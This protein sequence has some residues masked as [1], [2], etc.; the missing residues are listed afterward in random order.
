MKK[1]LIA[2]RLHP[3]A[4]EIL[5]A[6]GQYE[7]VQ[8]HSRPLEELAC[9]HSDTYALIVR[10][11]RVTPAIMD[12]MPSLK[13]IVRAGSGF[14]TIDVRYARQRGIDVMTT[15]GANANAVAE[16]V[17]AM[18][19]ADA[20]H[21]IAADISTRAGKWEKD[22]FMGREIAGKTV[23]IVGLGNV[24]RLVARR[25]AG[26]EVRLLAYDPN[27]STER[28]AELGV[29]MTDPTTL[30]SMADYITLH[31]PETEETRGFVNA[32]LL[33][34]LRAG[35]TIVNCARSGV[36]DEDALRSAKLEKGIRYLTDVYPEDGPGPKSIADVAD[37]MLPHLGANTVEAAVKA[38]RRAAEQLIDLDQKGITTFVVNRGVPEGLDEAYCDLA[39]KLARLCRSLLGMNVHLKLIETS[40]YGSLRP[41]AQWLLVPVVAGISEDFDRFM[42]YRAARRFLAEAG[43]DYVDREGDPR[44][45]YENSITVDLTGELEPGTLRHVSI[46]GTVAEGT[47]MV[48]RINEFNKLYFD[49][50]GDTVVFMY[51]DYPGILGTIGAGLA[52]AGVN[53]EDIRCPHELRTNR[54]LAILKVNR[55]PPPDVV[56]GIGRKIRAI[57]ACAI[58]L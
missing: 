5:M 33:K 32:G 51:E 13:V 22:R 21:I 35:A 10:S 1:V 9:I 47:L 3:V 26:F 52:A 42:D 30:F 24:G 25:L 49:P 19:L 38:A 16:E 20:R 27:V 57:T 29:E 53:I 12:A 36:V 8:D 4:R 45:G 15:P 43:I 56:D 31:L 14:N 46:R 41:F 6:N 54:S 2:T 18:M 11:E 7:V 17:V 55:C 50:S 48:S 39:Y 37:I 34:H 23:G 44:K 28:A 58:R 40:F